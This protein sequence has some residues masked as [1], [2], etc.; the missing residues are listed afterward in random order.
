MIPR[1]KVLVIAAALVAATAM[2][3]GEAHAVFS[4]QLH[5][6][7][8]S[9]F[10]GHNNWSPISY[11]G[12]IGHLPSPGYI[13]EGGEKFDIEGM[14]ADFGAS[15]LNVAV[16]SSFG[17]SVWSP[18]WGRSYRAGDFF[19]DIG[20]DGAY[21]FAVDRVSGRL[22]SGAGVT[23]WS[24]ITN[25]PGTYYSNVAIR[26]AV[27]AY[28]IN[29]SAGVVDHGAVTMQL[30]Q[31]LSLEAAPLSGSGDTYVWEA[32]IPYALMSGV[33]ASDA[34]RFHQ[35]IECGNDMAELD[36]VPAVP[37]PGTVM[38]LGSGLLG[39]GML[40]RRRKKS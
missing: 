34:A 30:T 11:P 28:R 19:I 3:P 29:F 14:W 1:A 17:N 20:N 18:T 26:N 37:E 25:T 4:W 21:D 24:T 10:D 12:G 32:R 23:N 8:A 13:G 38:L 7:G 31:H 40:V 22:Y 9:P 36:R 39:S 15:H 6:F 33:D 16:A 27:G 2:Q 35:T 5:N